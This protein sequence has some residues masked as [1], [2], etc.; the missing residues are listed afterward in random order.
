METRLSHFCREFE[1]RVRPLL[2]PVRSVAETLDASSSS[3]PV[4]QILPSLQEYAH[5]L[6][7]LIEKVAGQQAY[8]LIFGPL[9]SGKST[10]MN[11]LT[12]AYVS[13][14]TSLP[15]YPCLV[16]V[17]HSDTS[18]FV[19]TRYNGSVETLSDAALLRRRI[20]AAHKE[21]AERIRQVEQRGERFDPAV[22]FADAIRRVDV[23]VPAGDL[24]KS[25][26]V[27]VD[28]PGLYSRMRF[29][30]DRMAR[31]FRDTAACAIFVVKT[32]NLFLEQVLQEFNELLE[33]FSR[34]FLVVN[35]DSSKKD[36]AGDGGLIPSIERDHPER[37]IEAFESLSMSAPLKR[38]AEEGRL[39]ICTVD[40]LRAASCRLRAAF[41]QQLDDGSTESMTDPADPGPIEDAD[42]RAFLVE[43]TD[44][45]NSSDYLNAFLEDSLRYGRTL[46]GEIHALTRH[47]QVKDVGAQVNS[48]RLEIERERIL[49]EALAVTCRHDW[50]AL[51]GELEEEFRDTL[52]RRV[53]STGFSF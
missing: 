50:A 4:R 52:A 32:D 6:S 44:Y 26:A 19:L 5:K 29:G 38:A 17:S 2:E 45:L 23:K 40:L 8:A 43:L 11:A 51:F 3:L 16:Y 15:A 36:L 42:F 14:V 12:A 13:E 48:L 30:Y 25:S 10:L 24:E 28:T 41:A 39:R 22:H 35:I 21:L 1:H 37:I 47:P 27:L 46:L 18:E 53:D 7:V 34:I 31:D 49:H 20:S 33:L 9:K